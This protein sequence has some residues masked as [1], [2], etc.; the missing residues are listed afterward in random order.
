M[1][2][3]IVLMF[4]RDTLNF[5]IKGKEVFYSDRFWK[6][7]IRCLPRNDELIKQITLSRNKIPSFLAQLFNLS[8]KD[9]AEYDA[10]SSE[11][12]LSEIVIRDAK[13][14]SCRLISQ[15]KIET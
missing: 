15:E 1:A 6:N 9:I 12:E 7:Y 14:K 13:S 3:K 2:V 8:E 4:Q 5:I 10:A 11:E